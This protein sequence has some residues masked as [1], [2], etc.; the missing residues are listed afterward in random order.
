MIEPR[1][2]LENLV[3]EVIDSNEF[4]ITLI[5]NDDGFEE[6]F[7]ILHNYNDMDETDIVFA[8]QDEPKLDGYPVSVEAS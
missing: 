2:I 1:E 7:V 6:F 5:K 4:S 3:G 8:V